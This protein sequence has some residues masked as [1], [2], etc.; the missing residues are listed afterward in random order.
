MAG[1][2]DRLRSQ[3][4]DFLG[5]EPALARWRL[6]LIGVACAWI[7]QPSAAVAEPA[8]VYFDWQRPLASTCPPAKVLEAD[9]QDA[10]DRPVFTLEKSAPLHIE[11]RIE[12]QDSG[13]RVQLTARRRNGEVLG[14]RTLQARGGSCAALRSDIVL[15]L[16]L[17]VEQESVP[18]SN[19]SRWRLRPGMAATAAANLLPRW[20][21]G[22]GASLVLSLGDVLHF[23]ADLSYFLPLQIETAGGIRA[24]LTSGSLAM[25]AC[26][27]LLGSDDSRWALLACAGARVL[28]LLVS[29]E[30]PTQPASELRFSAQALVELRA[31]LRMGPDVTWELA[32]GPLFSFVR[33]S[34]YARYGAG[35][36]VL[37]YRSP[38]VGVQLQLGLVL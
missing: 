15:V 2:S 16:I 31:A 38:P 29:Q 7:M 13:T 21:A 24:D 25:S 27:R 11:G 10:L 18:S 17:L 26:P 9:V 1:A 6:L 36:E 28:G 20:T 14:T 37:L 22:L 5:I 3:S 33:T 19:K 12:E 23:R 30:Q 32:A 34:I 35:S 8:Q 4:S